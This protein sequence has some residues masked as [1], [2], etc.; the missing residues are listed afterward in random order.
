MREKNT[1]RTPPKQM[2]RR[3]VRLLKKERPDYH[4]TKKVFVYIRAALGFRGRPPPPK[5]LPQLLTEAEV[6]CFY[7]AVWDAA[8]RTHTVMIKLLLFTGIRNAELAAITLDDVDL[9]EC[10]LRI[11]Q[12]KGGKDRLVPFPRSFRGELGQYVSG[13]REQNATYLFETNRQDKFTTRW[14][15]AIVKRYAEKAGIRKHIYPHLFRHQLLTHLAKKGVVDAKLQVL[16]GHASRKS[17]EIYQDLSLVDVAEEY[18]Q[19]MQDF[20]IH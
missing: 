11:R 10:S 3:L 13:Q 1:E 2:A 7:E 14:I 5:R 20:P 9:K 19:A 12:G 8:D 18:Q 6:T 17:L 16:S 4:Y 15:R